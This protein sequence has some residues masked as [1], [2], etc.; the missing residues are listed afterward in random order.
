[1]RDSS[2]QQKIEILVEVL[3]QYSV[4][5]EEFLFHCPKCKHH[6]KKLSVNL[7]KNVFKCWVCDLTGSSLSRLIKSY[8]SFKNRNDWSVCDQSFSLSETSLEN[9]LFQKNENNEEKLISLPKEFVTLTG[10]TNHLA[11]AAIR[12]LKNERNITKEDILKWKIGYCGSGDYAGRIVIPSFNKNGYVNYFIARTYK[13][14]WI[15][16]K[17]PPI[18][19]SNMIFNHLYVDW[20]EDLVLTE[21]VFDAI[22]VGNA[23][24]LLGSTMMEYSTLFQEIAK[25]DTTIYLAL[26]PDAEK[27]ARALIKDMLRYGIEVFKVD[28]AGYQDVGSMTKEVFKQR[29]LNARS[30]TSDNMLLYQLE[31]I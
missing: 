15:K 21:G 30:M 16:Y 3:G 10:K 17:N 9:T 22:V 7:R 11:N 23:V 8:G 27:K 26:D 14:D 31:S 1:M 19:K 28:I 18:E 4:T 2:E 24:P 20:S 25:H 6:K 5:N 12:Y 29:K 13:N